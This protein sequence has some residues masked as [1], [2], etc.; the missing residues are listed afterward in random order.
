MHEHRLTE[1]FRQAPRAPT[2]EQ[3]AEWEAQNIGINPPYVTMTCEAS[4]IAIKCHFG[5]NSRKD[6]EDGVRLMAE[7][8]AE[9]LATDERFVRTLAHFD[10][11][12]AK[13]ERGE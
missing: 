2:D 3:W 13:K 11:L 5:G 4:G 9:T 1:T 6:Y 10:D 12:C 8:S 7:F